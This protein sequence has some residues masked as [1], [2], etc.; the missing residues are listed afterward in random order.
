[1]ENDSVLG[2]ENSSEEDKEL[3][4]FWIR[5]GASFLDSLFL[6]PLS[7][8]GFFAFIYAKDFYLYAFLTLVTFM[9]KPLMEGVW[10]A[11]LGKMVCKIEV[12]DISFQKLSFSKSIIRSIPWL[13]VSLSG[14]IQQ[15]PLFSLDDF[16]NADGYLEVLLVQSRS[17]PQTI[18]YFFQVILIVSG[19]FI[20]FKPRRGIH[21]FIAGSLC[22]YKMK[23]R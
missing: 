6:I 17:R 5:F 12:K 14:L 3:A 18:V 20:G 2:S 1:V 19:L 21:D 16:I 9:Y 7:A 4:G 13:F 22:I 10:G 11:T 8:L 15:Y 23:N